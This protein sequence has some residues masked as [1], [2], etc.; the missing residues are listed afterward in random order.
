MKTLVSYTDAGKAKL[1][2]EKKEVFGTSLSSLIEN[3]VTELGRLRGENGAV[4]G[5]LGT[6]GVSTVVDF[7]KYYNTKTE[8]VDIDKLLDD[9]FFVCVPTM[10]MEGYTQGTRATGVGFDPNR[11]YA[12]QIMNE[13]I[14]AMAFMASGIRWFTPRSTVW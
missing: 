10:N 1:E 3:Y 12:N 9:V 7:E 13:N 6:Y 8:T 14:N 4:S 2:Q 11:D 5:D